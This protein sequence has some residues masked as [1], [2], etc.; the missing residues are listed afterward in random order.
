MESQSYD[1][2]E[3]ARFK[4]GIINGHV[5]IITMFCDRHNYKV[6]S[7]DVTLAT[8]YGQLDAFI[9]LYDLAIK[10]G[11]LGSALLSKVQEAGMSNEF[12]DKLMKHLVTHYEENTPPEIVS[13]LLMLRNKPPEKF[14]EFLMMHNMVTRNGKS[15]ADYF[16]SGD[17]VDY[18]KYG[19]A[20]ASVAHEKA[21]VKHVQTIN[22]QI[23]R[24]C[25][26]LTTSYHCDMSICDELGAI[27]KS[28]GFKIQK[29]SVLEIGWEN[30]SLGIMAADDVGVNGFSKQ[31]REGISKSEKQGAIYYYRCSWYGDAKVCEE[32]GK[33]LEELGFMVV[34]I[35][36]LVLEW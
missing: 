29:E 7:D 28:A 21:I 14:D 11:C 3:Y 32:V 23:E 25:E 1:T 13:S 17:V 35:C 19:V 5:T 16:G 27:F 36:K 2:N 22:E 10:Q 4:S 24:H 33:E 18:K 9:V 8:R 31:V 30:R 12:H 6:T 34:K 15:L 26:N 20:P